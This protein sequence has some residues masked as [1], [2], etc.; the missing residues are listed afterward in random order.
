MANK[1]IAVVTG[2]EG[3]IG[4]SL[5]RELIKSDW[6]VIALHR[7][8][9]NLM[10]LAGVDVTLRACNIMVPS[11]LALAI[12]EN[13]HGIFHL[14]ADL[15][16]TH[17]RS[18]KQMG[19]NVDGTRNVLHAAIEKRCRRFLFTSSMGAFGMHPHRINE[20][21]AS[22][23]MA[24]PIHYF[25]S[26]YLGEI[27]V[28]KAIDRGLDAV[29]MNLS[30]VVGPRDTINIWATYIGL[31]YNSK[32]PAI[33][34]GAASFCHVREVARSM[35]SCIERGKTG[36]RYLLGGADTTFFE[37]G[38]I[39]QR[40]AGGHAPRMVVPSWMFRFAANIVSRY[41]WLRGGHT[42]LTPEMA[43]VISSKMLVDCSKAVRDLGYKVTS[44]EE[45]FRDEVEWLK[46]NNLLTRSTPWVWS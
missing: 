46:E 15:R 6:E 25:Q 30:N 26:K 5:V 39:I 23:A 4:S 27:E 42:F 45:M 10:R 11:H 16:I 21:T 32:I 12:P 22:N 7:P 17:R 33:G 1:K 19:V 28:E 13:A 2:A 36:E 14:A 40:I 35:I 9:A 38:K 8:G 41:A 44:L 3:F 18:S 43:L 24:L 29:I 34:P 31:V 20:T 37:L